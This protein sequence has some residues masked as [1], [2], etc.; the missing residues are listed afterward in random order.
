M[1]KP[2]CNDAWAC[3]SR[4]I[5]QTR[6]PCS[7]NAALRLTAE[8]VFPK[9]KAPQKILNITPQLK[10]VEAS[11]VK[12][13]AST[14][15]GLRGPFK[16][17]DFKDRSIKGKIAEFQRE[18][19]VKWSATKRWVKAKTS[20]MSNMR[21]WDDMARATD[22]LQDSVQPAG[23]VAKSTLKDKLPGKGL[24]QIGDR[25]VSVYGLMLIMAFGLVL[26]LMSVASP[27]SRLGGRH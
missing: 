19:K 20:H 21:T 16:F 1:P 3:G 22:R 9:K 14:K 2:K 25:T 24:V 13:P 15:M 12:P 10:S 17:A 26:L 18:T 27:T 4:S 6:F 8:V 5:S 23:Q 11:V 7:A